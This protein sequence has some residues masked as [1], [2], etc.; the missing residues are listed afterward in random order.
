MFLIVISM[1]PIILSGGTIEYTLFTLLPGVRISFKVDA[2]GLLFAT[3][4]SFL[5][6]PTTIY[7][8]GYMRSLNEHAQTRY[9]TC[10]SLSIS[11]HLRWPP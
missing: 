9:Y 11:F 3:T 8:I 7:S 4:A 6:I 1:A 5:W 2:L 10:F